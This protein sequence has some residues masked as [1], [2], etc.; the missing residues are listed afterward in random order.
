MKSPEDFKQMPLYKLD[1]T[2]EA[3]R[4]ALEDFDGKIPAEIVRGTP[5]G[6][7]LKCQRNWFQMVVSALELTIQHLEYN[8]IVVPDELSK[9]FLDY[10]SDKYKGHIITTEEEIER[11]N[12]TLKTC[13]VLLNK[14]K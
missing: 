4:H 2:I 12:E 8:S 1:E 6:K 11:A 3:V 9:Y 13:S 10:T 5:D 14:L 7:L